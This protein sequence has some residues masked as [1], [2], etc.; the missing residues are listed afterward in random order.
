[1]ARYSFRSVTLFIGLVLFGANACGDDGPITTPLDVLQ[2]VTNDVSDLLGDDVEDVDDVDDVAT[3]TASLMPNLDF[4]F[5]TALG[6]KGEGA[7]EVEIGLTDELAD[8][9]QTPGFQLNIAV[10]TTNIEAGRQV[11]LLVAGNQVATTAVTVIQGAD[12]GTALFEGV[13]LTHDTDG[14][15]VVVEATN[16]HGDVATATKLVKVDIGTCGVALVP[17]NTSCVLEDADPVTDGFQVTF[18]VTN[19]DKTCHE[20]RLTYM[21]NGT[22]D[23]ATE[24]VELD[25]TGAAEFTITLLST[26]TADGAKTTVGAEVRDKKAEE[27]TGYLAHA[28]YTMDSTNP[29]VSI[30]LP[31]KNLLTLADDNDADPSNG[32]TIDVSGV[33]DGLP[34]GSEVALSINDQPRG[35]AIPNPDGTYLFDDIDITADGTYVLKVTVEDAC[36]RQG[37]AE[38]TIDARV[39]QAAYVFVFPAQGGLLLARDDANP[40]TGMTYEAEFVVEA[41]DVA[42]GTTLDVRCRADIEGSPEIS[43]GGTTVDTLALDSRYSLT[44]ELDVAILGNA[45][46]CRVVDDSPNPGTSAEVRFTVALPA[47]YLAIREPEAEGKLVKASPLSISLQT[48]N[49]DGVIPTLRVVDSSDSV[50]IVHQPTTAIQTSGATYDLALEN[51]GVLIPDGSYTLIVEAA[52]AFGNA[53]GDITGNVT[54]RSFILDTLAPIVAITGP[55]HDDLEPA[56]NPADAD[57]DAGK[58]GHQTT[59]T[60]TLSGDVA[61]ATEVC[62]QA[63]GSDV[64]KTVEGRDLDVDFEGVTLQPGTNELRAWATD[65]AGNRSTDTT[66]TLNLITDGPRLTI[67]EPAV[68]GFVAQGNLPIDLKVLVTDAD[69][70]ALDSVEVMLIQDDVD[71]PKATSGADGIA[72]FAIASLSAT[73]NAFMTSA[74]VGG[75]TGYSAPR[76]LTLKET[77]PEIVFA[78][79][80]DGDSINLAY[81]HCAPGA[82]DCTMNV[83][84]SST[85]LEVGASGTLTINCG[86]GPIEVPGAAVQQGEAVVLVFNN[87]TLT[88]QATCSLSAVVTDLAGQSASAGPIEVVVDRVAP[89]QPIFLQP[90]STTLSLFY[91]NDED[92]AQDGMQY[93][94]RV[95]VG[96]VETGRELTVQYGLVGNVPVTIKYPLTKNVADGTTLDLTMPQVTLAGGT[97]LLKTE[98]SDAAGNESSLQ[99]LINVYENLA[100]VRIIR[101]SNITATACET[102]D[103]CAS[104]GVCAEGLCRIPWSKSSNRTLRLSYIGLASA[105]QGLRVCSNAPGLG[106]TACATEGY[107]QIASTTATSSS[108]TLDIAIAVNDGSYSLIAEGLSPD[109][110][111]VSSLASPL[112]GEQ[113][114]LIYQDTVNPEVSS[115][116]SPSDAN[117]DNLLNIAERRATDRDYD[118]RVQG[119]E[120][121]TV[122]IYVN[123]TEQGVG[124]E[125]NLDETLVASLKENSN[126]IY[127]VIRDVA[128]NYSAVP[129]ATVIYYRPTVDTTVPAVSWLSPAENT[130][131]ADQSR[132]IVILSDEEDRQVNVLDGGTQV[133]TST[134]GADGTATFAW[135]DDHIL[136]DG[137]HQLSADVT[138]LAGNTGTAQITV[139]VDTV[140]PDVNISAPTQGL[141]LG[142][143]NDALP[144]VSGFQIEAKFG[145]T[146]SDSVT[147]RVEIASGCNDQWTNCNAAVVAGQSAIT[148]IGG[149]EPTFFTTITDFS[150]PYHLVMVK[151]FDEIGNWTMAQAGINVT[152]TSCQVSVGGVVAGGYVNNSSCAVAGEN[153]A[154]VNREITVTAMPSC[155]AVDKMYLA[156]DEG[157]P[158]QMVPV[159]QT[160]TFSVSLVNGATP[161]F[162]G[163]AEVLGSIVGSSAPIEI[164]VDLID[165]VAIFTNPVDGS[166]NKWGISKDLAEGTAGLQK[167]FALSISDINLDGGTL[168]S[169]T[170][171]TGFGSQSLSLASPVLPFSLTGSTANVSLTNVTIPDQTDGTVIAEV[172]DV[173]GNTAESD[174]L[175]E[176]DLIAPSPVVLNALTGAD[177]DRRRPAVSLSWMAVGDNDNVAGTSAT[178][179]DIRYSTQPIDDS[180]FETACTVEGLLF[181]DTLPTPAEQGTPE[182]FSVTGPDTRAGNYEENSQPCKLV[183]GTSGMAEYHFAVRAT[184]DVGNVSTIGTSS[185]VSADFA[186]RFAMFTGSG[187]PWDSTDFQARVM[188]VGDLDNDGLDDI[189]L[190]GYATE[191]FCI[192]YGFADG[193][194]LVDDIVID[195]ASGTHHQCFSGTT[196]TKFGWPV[197]GLGDVNGD[198]VDDLGVGEGSS[199]TPYQL[200]VFMGVAGGRLASTPE[201]VV[202]GL[203]GGGSGV[204]AAGRGDFNGDGIDDI[205]VGARAANKAF[206]IPGNA[207]WVAGSTLTINVSESIALATNN[208]VEFAMVGGVSNSYFGMNVGFLGDVDDDGRDEAL[209]SVHAVPSQI[210][211]FRGRDTVGYQ[212]AQVTFAAYAEGDDPTATRLLP[213]VTSKWGFGTFALSGMADVDGDGKADVLADHYLGGGSTEPYGQSIFG[214]YG[215]YIGERPGET[216]RIQTAPLIG[217]GIERNFLGFYIRGPYQQVRPIGN[218]DNAPG[219]SSEDF[220]YIK[221]STAGNYGTVTIRNNLVDE[222]NG[223]GLGYFPYAAPVL[224]DPY[225]PADLRFGKNLADGLGDFN[226]DGLPDLLI[227]TNSAGYSMLMY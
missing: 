135:D 109:E 25:N 118:I 7:S 120:A 103:S 163:A 57:S 201:V 41:Q 152:L 204:A 185:T 52:D 111:W 168:A 196:G 81:A 133:A 218:F 36:G 83:D 84:L 159:G 3:D 27:R 132:D 88:D 110:N 37:S 147:W 76:T 99:R 195:N 128:G 15:D 74:T 9:L 102:S 5:E 123:G 173:A 59:I 162:V 4:L 125:F 217:D 100:I 194:G 97:L 192:V 224:E 157:T 219:A 150:T 153:C 79:P 32:L 122:S 49:L 166:D 188:G 19:P 106:S 206:L 164:T 124:T 170:Y 42:V 154:E 101:P 126:E 28:E 45:V 91:I 183:T 17:K 63:N 35:T 198:G 140:L 107:S 186:L 129:P 11:V 70:T 58:P 197:V 86:D 75:I 18:T 208:V 222:S 165:P 114:R 2:D 169:L 39:S 92:A 148:N 90:S 73:V 223:I 64:C 121:G 187:T 178:G 60:V 171:E 179:Y 56:V 47:P 167:N 71:G 155:G 213:E 55:D 127:A 77:T 51:G 46:S 205:V 14:Y 189:A 131:K 190:G 146:S 227:G 180:N 96:G 65:L 211:V 200:S 176:V 30:L 85:N 68:D 158:L 16:A 80:L 48:T 141:A 95:R 72:T 214:F 143:E 94:L 182:T 212:K 40:E 199:S 160:A 202:T 115:V 6:S 138:D 44:A 139:T 130:I 23:R 67:I 226:G 50:V 38:W 144:A 31:D 177:I 69:G 21:R 137:V 149:Q 8:Y 62:L 209:V 10:E 220:A 174:F 105:E 119:N 12:T 215:K 116:T 184:D 113:I 181:T 210:F 108:A 87:I 98:I 82:T 145:T 61:P 24:W 20:A 151:M 33:A 22:E 117:A 66:R 203:S 112:L 29:T 207:D 175:A 156:I 34:T 13:T 134:I 136:T 1:M 104:G 89:A 221:Y 193:D 142:D 216:I 225:S 161:S 53:V 54:R 93:T 191:T 26:D 43:I 78:T 172:T